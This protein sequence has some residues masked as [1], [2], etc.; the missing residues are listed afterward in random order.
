MRLNIPTTSWCWIGLLFLSAQVAASQQVIELR[1]GFEKIPLKQ[2]LTYTI[3]YTGGHTIADVRKH[4][5]GTEIGDSYPSFK[6]TEHA[7]W[8]FF[9]IKNLSRSSQKVSLITKGIDSVQTYIAVAKGLAFAFAPTGSHTPIFRRNTVSPLLCTT[10]EMRPQTTYSVWVRLRNVNYRLSA[11][12]FDLYSY[13][14]GARFLFRKHFFYSLY[15][16]SMFLILL[17]GLALVYF[18]KE[19]IYWY[20]LGCVSCAA[21]I[22][23]VYN[24]FLY[25][26]TNQLPTIVRNKNALG[27]LSASVPV[28]YLLFAEKF[29]GITIKPQSWL[30]IASRSIIGLQYLIMA[31]LMLAGEALFDYRGIFYFSMFALSAITLYYLFAKI[32]TAPAKLFLAATFPVNVIVILET[33]ST[34]HQIPTQNIHDLYYATTLFELLLL[35]CGIVYRFRRS[36]MEKLRLQY[37]ILDIEVETRT[38]I[39][40]TIAHKLHD[41]AAG[42]LV[43]VK[44]KLGEMQ[45]SDSISSEDWGAVFRWLDQAYN[46]VR[47]LSHKLEESQTRQPLIVKLTERFDGESKVAID[48]EGLPLNT[49]LDSN[50]EAILFNVVSE[51]ITNALKHAQPRHIHAQLSYDAPFFEAIIEDD[52]R[53]FNP[54]RARKNGNGYG[55]GKIKSRVQSLDGKMFIDSNRTGTVVIIKAKFET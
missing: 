11:S 50:A 46:L 24:D 21:L 40:D 10:F 7:H 42:D 48:H 18:F 53:G 2:N 39:V 28:F 5:R 9:R 19:K 14:A 16:G 30:F 23:F 36:E 8:L 41:E 43:L 45:R 47:D 27:I 52:G 33:F 1:E 37:E 54:E 55:L 4:F 26:L 22:M 6:D 29:L 44:S 34:L 12:P 51:V 20:Y 15:L 17:F 32:R 31:G 13:E 3:D 25:L 38:E 49:I 35:T